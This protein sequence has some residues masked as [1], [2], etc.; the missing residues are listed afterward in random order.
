MEHAGQEGFDAE[1]NAAAGANLHGTDLQQQKY[2]LATYSFSLYLKDIM[3]RNG[4]KTNSLA[5]P[6]AQ[7]SPDDS[8]H[9]PS[10]T[11]GLTIKH[12]TNK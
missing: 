7:P 1:K 8:M 9:I 10:L 2:P 5:T 4:T 6:R 11:S 3:L 12:K